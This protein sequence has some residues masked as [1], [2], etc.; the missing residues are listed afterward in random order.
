MAYIENDELLMK[1]KRQDR[2]VTSNSHNERCRLI[3]HFIE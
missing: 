1:T 3:F 2:K